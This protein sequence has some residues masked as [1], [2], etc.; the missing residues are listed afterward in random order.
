MLNDF[1]KAITALI[2]LIAT[3]TFGLGVLTG[4]YFL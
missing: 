2:V 4:W 3:I 1:H